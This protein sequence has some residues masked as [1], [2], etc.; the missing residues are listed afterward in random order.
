MTREYFLITTAN[1]NFWDNSKNILFLGTWCKRFDKEDSWGKFNH[2]IIDCPIRDFS[3]AKETYYKLDE[4]FESILPILTEALNNLHKTNHNIDYW[5]IIIGPWLS[6]YINVIYDRYIHITNALNKYPNLDTTVLSE[7]SFIIPFNTRDFTTLLSED[8]YN[9][10]IFTKIFLFLG[11]K[12]KCKKINIDRNYMFTVL[13]K[14]GFRSKILDLISIFHKSIITKILPAS[15]LFQSAPFPKLFELLLLVKFCGRALSM[16]EVNNKQLPLFKFDIKKRIL[17]KNLF[18]GEDQFL[19]CLS[20][21]VYSD[22]PIC[23]VEGFHSSCILGNKKYPRNV[24]VILSANSWQ[25]DEVFKCWAAEQYEKG[26]VLLGSAHGGFLAGRPFMNESKHELMILDYFY[27]WG[28]KVKGF[29][30]ELIPMPAGK[31]IGRKKIGAN[32]SK[33]GILWSTTTQPR[34]LCEYPSSPLFFEEY[35]NWHKRFV[36]TLPR[37]IVEEICV[38]THREDHGWNIDKRIIKYLKHN[39]FESWDIKFDKSLSKYRLYVCDHFS[40]T[41]AESLAAN[42]PTILFWNP[43]FND[44]RPEAKPFFDLLKENGI[45][46]NTP[47]SAAE[48]ICEIY[49]NIES[50]W[51]ESSRQKSII[52][53]CQHGAL[54]SPNSMKLWLS[55]LENKINNP[56]K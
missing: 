49:D 46:H 29:K 39:R 53:F 7:E 45:L 14:K 44:L 4:Y 34:Y 21:L 6:K 37:S 25:N 22:L 41:Y 10:Q 52:N 23:F 3:T 50:W 33:K 55:E 42:M 38:R 18:F 15:I 2:Q 13:T 30:A 43:E 16:T 27:S 8:L 48:T 1:Q 5:R 12:Y 17:I 31:L 36:K 9:L 56:R 32:S 20:E 40:T 24:D 54:T 51:N 11:K 26:A 35:L 28:Y 47:E 19:K